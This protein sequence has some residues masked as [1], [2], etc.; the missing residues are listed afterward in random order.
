MTRVARVLLV[1]GEDAFRTALQTRLEQAGH[2]VACARDPEEARGL[3]NEGLVPDVVV[4]EVPGD[5]LQA[6]RELAPL[7]AH[8]RI[9]REREPSHSKTLEEAPAEGGLAECSADPG[10]VLRRIEEVLLDHSRIGADDTAEQCLD[11]ARRLSNSLPNVAATEQR[12]ELITEAFDTF[13]GVEGS[14]VVRRGESPDSWIEASRGLGAELVTRIGEEI[15]RRSAHRDI[16]PFL[17]RLDAAG[18]T[19]DVA[20]AAVSVGEEEID[21]AL[22]LRSAPSDPAL[23]ESL[24]N[25]VGAA[26]RAAI[27][28]SELDRARALVE[29]HQESFRSLLQMS[30]ELS[31]V[32]G[33]RALAER[34][35]AIL[36]RELGIPRAALFAP[37]ENQGMLDLVASTGF[38]RVA[39]ERI[40]LS[41]FHGVGHDCLVANEL[42]RLSEVDTEGVA[43]RELSILFKAG[44][45]WSIALS[46]DGRALGLLF[47]GSREDHSGFPEGDRQVLYA[48]RE[49]TVVALRNLQR[50][51]ELRS[52]ALRSLRGLVAATELRHPVDRGHAERVTRDAVVAGRALGL[53]AVELRDLAYGAMLHDVGKLALGDEEG[54]RQRLHPVAGSRILAGANPGAVV[55]QIVEQHHERVDGLGHPY[56]LRGDGIHRL[57]RLVSVADAFDHMIHRQGLERD[58]AL[59]RLERGAGLVWDPG[60]VALFSAEVGR[61]PSESKSDE[62]WLEE[63]IG[64]Y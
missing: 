62:N 38:P 35:L 44:L 26:L 30:R 12:I 55:V 3:L 27:R 5:G 53:S 31:E 11:L 61:N 23:R 1:E 57:A 63:L 29:A 15:L 39:L 41:G 4:A 50:M 49:A 40:G 25:L 43:A 20:C 36:H 13:F 8:L 28:V 42:V 7:A 24:M 45:K 22:V 56:G 32:G 54:S 58:Q 48:L 14:Y 37:R 60:M 34:I 9:V 2:E 51:E 6:M 10:E 16:R 46:H 19:H 47:F 59:E 64:A 18:A 33:Q 17:A 21:L 52:L